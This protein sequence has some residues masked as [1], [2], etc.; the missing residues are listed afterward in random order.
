MPLVRLSRSPHFR[1]DRSVRQDA[2][3]NVKIFD[4]SKPETWY[5]W[6]SVRL[7]APA[8]VPDERVTLM[9]K[10]KWV[11]IAIAAVLKEDPEREILKV[12]GPFRD[13]SL[14]AEGITDPDR[15]S[16]LV[17]VQY[18]RRPVTVTMKDVAVKD[19][20]LMQTLGWKLK[21]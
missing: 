6:R 17:W 21:E 11:N 4:L 12:D 7:G 16:F 19:V 15:K 10:Q 3:R 18:K 8:S 2:R 14:L 20:P 1:R 13:K 5:P 9:D